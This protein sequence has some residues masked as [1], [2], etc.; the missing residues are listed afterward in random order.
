M[1]DKSG[2]LEERIAHIQERLEILNSERAI[3]IE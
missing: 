2:D 1:N 3:L